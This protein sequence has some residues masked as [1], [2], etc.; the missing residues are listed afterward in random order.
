MSED[1]RGHLTAI[2][3]PYLEHKNKYNW[4]SG[5]YVTHI[6]TIKTSL[7]GVWKQPK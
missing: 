4:L 7:S 6:L 5:L 3:S 1:Q 2:E